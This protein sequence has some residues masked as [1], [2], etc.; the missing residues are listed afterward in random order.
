M[1]APKARTHGLPGLAL[2]VFLALAAC[3]ADKLDMGTVES[4]IGRELERQL[5]ESLDVTCPDEVEVRE[6][7]TFVCTTTTSDGPATI[8]VTQRNDRGALR[9]RLE[10]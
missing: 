4:R 1:R 9:F 3:G 6:G 2:L 7:D 5:D 10:R 8:A